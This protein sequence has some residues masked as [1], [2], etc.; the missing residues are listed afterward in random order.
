MTQLMK[1]V[2]KR[3]VPNILLVHITRNQKNIRNIKNPTKQI[4]PIRNIKNQRRDTVITPI[5]LRNHSQ[6]MSQLWRNVKAVL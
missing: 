1:M 2:L 3:N 5:P 4:N 6:V